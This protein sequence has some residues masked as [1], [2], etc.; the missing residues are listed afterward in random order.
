[1]L[2]RGPAA[3][4]VPPP[5]NRNVRKA[6]RLGIFSDVEM[7]VSVLLA[8][9]TPLPLA[10]RLFCVWGCSKSFFMALMEERI[11]ELAESAAA[12][13]SP[14]TSPFCREVRQV[15]FNAWHYVDA[16]LWASLAA[17]LFDELARAHAPDVTQIKLTELDEARKKAEEA[18]EAR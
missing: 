17:T 8:R 18:R 2:S 5:G 15:R 13:E 16:N 3:A 12:Q 9:D 11:S 14:E 7:L 6:D 1:T 4:A 10:V